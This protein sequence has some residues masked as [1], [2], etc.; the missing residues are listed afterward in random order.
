MILSTSPRILLISTLFMMH[1]SILRSASDLSQKPSHLRFTNNRKELKSTG[2]PTVLQQLGA[3]LQGTPDHDAQPTSYNQ[4][5]LPDPQSAPRSSS[6][7]KAL[8][9]P[10]LIEASPSLQPTTQSIPPALPQI[11][12]VN[13]EESFRAELEALKAENMRLAAMVAAKQDATLT[14]I[15]PEQVSLNSDMSKITALQETVNVLTTM[16]QTAEQRRITEENSAPTTSVLPAK[17]SSKDNLTSTNPEP[18]QSGPNPSN[19]SKPSSFEDLGEQSHEPTAALPD[20]LTPQP[21]V[22]TSFNQLGTAYP[23]PT[24]PPQTATDYAWSDI[25]TLSSDEQYA[26]RLIL[27]GTYE[28]AYTG[29]KADPKLTGR[30]SNG[31]CNLIAALRQQESQHRKAQR[32]L[33]TTQRAEFSTASNRVLS[34]LAAINAHTHPKKIDAVRL[35]EDF[36]HIQTERDENQKLLKILLQEALARD[37]HLK[38]QQSALSDAHLTGK[39]SLP[40]TPRKSLQQ[41]TDNVLERKTT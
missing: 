17:Q 25:H 27:N 5:A 11:L 26:L 18:S 39:E 1:F 29:A 24:L 33:S 20:H 22:T 15:T 6:P 37:N 10:A 9:T 23:M 28:V 41:F 30:N 31:L 7:N 3:L 14:P 36:E 16:L 21:T 19:I 32:H 34:L 38:D 8:Q 13:P 4:P 12:T 35:V 40:I 2:A